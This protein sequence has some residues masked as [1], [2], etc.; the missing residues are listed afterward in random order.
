MPLFSKDKEPEPAPA[1]TSTSSKGG[2]FNRRR[3]SSPDV[4]SPNRSSTSGGLRNVLHRNHNEDPAIREAR[5]RVAR[6]E[7]AERDADRA[8]IQARTAVKEARAHVKRME[9]E[10]AEEYV[11]SQSLWHGS[12]TDVDYR[13]RLAKIK[14]GQ[15][16]DLKN[17]VKGL[18]RH[19]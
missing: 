2:L 1:R 14:Q 4:T 9:E 19:G 7:Q 12:D 6:A 3:S 15:A 5:E 18:G 13:A 8:L 11:A 16:K 17:S 10:A